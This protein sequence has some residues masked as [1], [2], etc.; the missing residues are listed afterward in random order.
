MT[1]GEIIVLLLFVIGLICSLTLFSW[2]IRLVRRD[3]K[4]TPDS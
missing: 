2:L 3:G 1:T 4:K